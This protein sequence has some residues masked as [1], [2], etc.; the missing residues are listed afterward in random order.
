M[1]TGNNQKVQQYATDLNKVKD[2]KKV[3]IAPGHVMIELIQKKDSK[4]I[5]PEGSGVNSLVIAKVVKVGE[6]VKTV[7]TGDIVLEVKSFGPHSFSRCKKDDKIYLVTDQY[8][9]L[10]W[11]SLDNY[12]AK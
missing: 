7:K 5:L 4:I 9:I 8:N 10:L 12:E 6:N 2:I 3:N 11:T 1:E